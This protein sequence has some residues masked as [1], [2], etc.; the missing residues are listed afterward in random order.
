MSNWVSYPYPMGIDFG[1][2]PPTKE[3][4][5][6]SA[7][8]AEPESDD[9]LRKRIVYVAGDSAAFVQ[10]VMRVQGKDLDDIAERYQLRRR[11]V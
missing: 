11:N 5:K 10:E 9:S 4:V 8:V 2:D 3:V 1:F 7:P 6:H